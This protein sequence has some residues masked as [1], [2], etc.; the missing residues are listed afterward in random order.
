MDK[1]IELA[2]S[3]FVLAQIIIILSG[4]F[5]AASGIAWVNSTNT[6]IF[7]LDLAEKSSSKNCDQLNN[8][9]NYQ[10]FV[11][12]TLGYTHESI[13]SSLNL[14][15]FYFKLGWFLVFISIFIW[16]FGKYKLENLPNNNNF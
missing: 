3:W 8:L 16:W 9:S 1:E 7:G 5:F 15:K 10:E 2:K 13:L 6:M 14:W 12:E 11:G 4:F